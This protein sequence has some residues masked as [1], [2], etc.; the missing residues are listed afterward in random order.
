[1]KRE[2]EVEKRIDYLIREKKKKI[3][4]LKRERDR[5]EY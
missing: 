2:N 4:N 3:G 5:E 1:M